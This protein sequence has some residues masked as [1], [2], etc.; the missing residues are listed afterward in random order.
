MRKSISNLDDSMREW[1]MMASLILDSDAD[2]FVVIHGTDTM[3]Y[4]SSALSFML[5]NLRKP[6][7]ITG[8]QIPMCNPNSDGK[9]NLA[10]SFN[11]VRMLYSKGIHAVAVYFAQ[12]LMRGV[13]VTKCSAVRLDAFAD[14]GSTPY[15]ID[16]ETVQ[17][18][19]SR[20]DFSSAANYI[21]LVANFE[22]GIPFHM[23]P[24]HDRVAIFMITPDFSIDLLR[25]ILETSDGLLLMTYGANNVP[26]NRP[27]MMSVL[28]EYVDKG[29]LIVSL[30][31]VFHKA[32]TQ[33]EYE[34]GNVLHEIGVVDGNAMT[35]EATFMK[36]RWLLATSLDAQQRRNAMRCNFMGEYPGENHVDC[37]H[38]WNMIG[39]RNTCNI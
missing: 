10:G 27:E 5:Y 17:M 12:R 32:T 11:A 9:A 19:R 23:T 36:M 29:K 34:T 38:L 21:R 13:T 33:S 20:Y 37:H 6:V 8:S 24:L 16:A 26:S 3:A 30:S 4:T 31:Q 39:Q 14:P 2:A 22:N 18:Q 28:A 25:S 35:M 7:V 1:T 15:T